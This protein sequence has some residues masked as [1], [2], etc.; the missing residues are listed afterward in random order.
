MTA[1]AGPPAAFTPSDL[2][3]IALLPMLIVFGA[4]V[5]GVV[6]EA[7][8]PRTYRYAVHVSLTVVALVAAL[9]ALVLGAVHH[10]V[11]SAGV[12]RAEGTVGVGAVVIDG[13]TLF[14]QGAVLVFS[15][16]AAL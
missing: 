5:L 13:P 1:L 12:P 8:V 11:Q 4:A 16:L 10:Q 3:Y 6:A 14:I 9:L 7:F 2:D 15:L